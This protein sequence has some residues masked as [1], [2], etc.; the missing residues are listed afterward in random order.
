MRPAALLS[1]LA[2]S[3]LAAASSAQ[4]PADAPSA[5]AMLVIGGAGAADPESREA[6]RREIAAL[7][8][9][10][11]RIASSQARGG[12]DVEAARQRLALLNARE[13]ALTGQMARE[14]ARLGGLFA[15]LTLFRRDPPPALLVRP[16]DARDAVR[17]AI[18]MRAMTPEL[19]R[20]ARVYAGEAREIAA[21]RRQAAGANAQLFA[22]ESQMAGRRSDLERLLAQQREIELRYPQVA[23]AAGREAGSPGA[24]V[25]SFP[26]RANAGQGPGALRRPV[27]GPVVRGYS[28]PGSP[29]LWLRAQAGGEVVSPVQGRVEFAGPVTGWGVILILRTPDG[30]H[31]VLAGLDQANVAAGLSVTAGQPVGRM[32]AGAGG[33]PELYLE[34]RRDGAP[35]DPAR[36]LS[37]R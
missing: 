31:L 20:R 8:E 21:L 34:L 12:A 9:D 14:R 19:E 32:A 2:L 30:F 15:A 33:A 25:D 35:V 37:A 17:A 29:G 5:N 7:R 6:A 16:D 24:L 18:L 36:W 28:A 23:Q 3:V 13:S 10:L 4:E 11:R 1:I 26:R 22:A 27:A